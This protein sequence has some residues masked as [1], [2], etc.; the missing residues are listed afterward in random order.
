MKKT[1]FRLDLAEALL[2]VN[3][4]KPLDKRI[5]VR[6][7]QTLHYLNELELNSSKASW[8][9]QH[10]DMTNWKFSLNSI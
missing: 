1:A 4:L 5:Q 9:L 6:D 10:F 2:A 7:N 3:S 8:I